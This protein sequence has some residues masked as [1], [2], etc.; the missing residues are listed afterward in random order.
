MRWMR[1]MMA[2][3]VMGVVSGCAGSRVHQEVSRLVSQVGLL[4][5]RVAQLER[6]ATTSGWSAGGP[7]SSGHRSRAQLDPG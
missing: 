7:L 2:V 5:E 4:E 3:A 6:S 1:A